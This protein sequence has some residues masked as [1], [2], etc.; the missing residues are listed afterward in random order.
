MADVH[1]LGVQRV[2]LPLPGHGV[3]ITADGHPV[4]AQREDLVLRAD[5][6]GPHLAAWVL[7]AHGGKQSDAHKIFIPVDVIG[8]FHNMSP[9]VLN[10]PSRL[11]SIREIDYTTNRKGAVRNGQ[12]LLGLVKKND[13]LLGRLWAVFFVT[14]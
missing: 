6:A 10:A 4:I 13:R 2:A 7:G 3:I 1:I 8:A 12:L 9:L 14:E 5:D 11:D